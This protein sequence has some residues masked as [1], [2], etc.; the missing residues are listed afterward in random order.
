MKLSLPVMGVCLSVL[1]VV[2]PRAP[3]WGQTHTS[4][5]LESQVYY[6]LEQAEIRGLCRPLSG[7]RPYTQS[8]IAEAIN[9]ILAAD[10]SK[11][12][13]QERGILERY[14][15][16]F[17]K[18]KPGI[19]WQRGAWYGE[20][21]LGKNNIILSA[22][23]G[24]SA[25]I[26]GSAAFYSSLKNRYFGTEIW[27]HAFVNGDLGSH[28][29]Y[30]I[31]GEGGLMQAPRKKMGDYHNYYDGF[32][33]PN[34][35]LVDY[36]FDVYSEPLTSF[37][38]TYQKRWDGSVHF[39]RNLSGYEYWPD[40]A[41]LAYNL[42]SELTAVFLENK[43]IMRLGRL[44][45]EW[46]STS[47]GSSLGLNQMARPFLGVEAEFNPVSWFGIATLTGALEYINDQDIKTSAFA[48]Q[49]L[50][51]A[52]MVQFRYKNYV[53]LDVIDAVVYP[54]RFELGYISPIT[55]T[56]FYQDSVGDFDNMA[57]TYNL[58]AQ[59]PGLGNIWFSFFVDE[60][61]L[62]RDFFTLDRQMI[63]IQGGVNIPLPFLSFSS[64][65]LSYTKVNPYTYTH[66]RNKNPWYNEPMETSYTNNG[67]GLG[68]YLP[69]NAD[70]ILVRFN[71]MPTSNINAHLQY[72]L[73]RHGAD[74]GPSAVDGSNLRSELATGENTNRNTDAVLKRY[75][76]RDG[77]YQWSHIA[78]VGAEWNL[79]GMPVSLFGE[80]GAVISYF[81]NTKEDANT[82]KPH[83]YKIIDTAVYPKTTG[84]IVS[85][86]VRIFPR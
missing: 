3:L 50:F 84:F 68:Y 72:Q 42:T 35:E 4:V 8:V 82:G 12:N 78:R 57:M 36:T 69:P 58:R 32:T 30:D 41:A 54:K 22:N 46:G 53:S 13:Q 15:L 80:A 73:I 18:P 83:N 45:H 62:M 9:E 74:F 20:T 56:F 40:S 37:P 31:N 5:T 19:D 48:F 25:D 17:A 24:L 28:V 1:L 21:A 59:Y 66:N 27:V 60:M 52:T 47:L 86:G 85:L 38:Y 81:T 64:I 63:A 26:E 70:E 6:I 71:T 65:K 34:S 29:S 76:L 7:A 61:H 23:A 2:S 67:V 77:A 49:N 16:Q 79:P 44:R 14:R 55:N 11:L 33:A 75:F 39:A 51:S 10:Q 43:L